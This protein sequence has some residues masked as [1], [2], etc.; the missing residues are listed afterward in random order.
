MHV[1]KIYGIKIFSRYI[2]CFSLCICIHFLQA[3]VTTGAS[4]S[5]GLR[6]LNPSYAGK[7]IQVRRTCDNAVKD[8]GFSACGGLDLTT[9]N[10]FVTA[11]NPVSA[12]S[13]VPAAAYS[14]RKYS[15]SY[16]GNAINVRRSCDNVTKDIGFTATGDLD[17]V[18]LKL[19]VLASNPL[20]ALSVSS[21]AAFSLRKLSCA[22]A[23]SAIN[24]RRSSDNTTSDIGFTA[25]G[26]LDT[27]ALKAF[28]GANNGFVT[29][30]YDQSGNGNHASQATTTNQPELVVAGV[31]NRQNTQ[32]AVIF[33]AALTSYL[34]I[35]Y[36][37]GSLN[38]SSASTANTVLARTGAPTGD[39]AVFDQQYAPSNISVALSWNNGTGAA[40]PLSMGYYSTTWQ[41]AALPV[42][43]ILNTGNILT[44]TI[45]SGAGNTTAINMYQNGGLVATATSQLTVGAIAAQ[46]FNIGK[47]WDNANY[48]PMNLQE[49]IVFSSALSATDRQYLEWG[50][51]QYYNTSG[52]S[53]TA[54]PAATPSAFVTKWY[55]Q[56][57]NTRDASQATAANQPRI[58]N[59]GVID[60][61]NGL[62]AIRYIGASNTYLSVPQASLFPL[63]DSYN[64]GSADVATA[65]SNW[66]GAYRTGGNTGANNRSLANGESPGLSGFSIWADWGGYAV[67]TVNVNQTGTR[68]LVSASLSQVTSTEPAPV[69]AATYAST[70]IT[71]GGDASST[72]AALTGYLCDVIFFSTALSATDRAYIE[73]SQ[74]QYYGISGIAVASMPASPPSG[75][76]TKWYDQSGNGK[77]L[78]QATTTNQPKIVNAGVVTLQNGLPAMPLDGVNYYMGQSTLNIANPYTANAVATRTG[79]AGGS[80]SGY[81][82]LLNIS[83]TGDSY[84]FMGTLTAAGVVNYATFTGNGA[85]T[86]NDIAANT[87]L[88]S[89]ALNTQSVLTMGVSTGAT[90]LIPYFN[91][92][93]LT[94]TVGTA[95]T[96][97]G[98]LIG[99]PYSG[100]T[101]NQLWTGNISEF[102]LFPSAI[103]TT[104]RTLL[105]TN[106][107]AYYGATISN[108]VYTPPVAGTYNLFVNGV[109]RTSATDSVTATR[110]SAGMGFIVGQT[111]ADFLKDNG[112]YIT[113]GVSC[114]AGAVSILNLPAAATER[115][116]SDWYINK[117][118]VGNDGGNLQIYFSFSDYGVIGA[119][120]TA[121]N[122]MLLGRSSAV[123]SFTVVPTTTVTIVGSRIV[124]TL[125]STNLG[126]NG[127]YTVGTADYVASP[128]PIELL[129]FTAVPDGN[130]VDLKWETVTET[131]NAYFTIEKSKDGISFTKLIDV[132]GAG[133]STSTKEYAETDYQPYTGTS[134]YRLKQTDIN[135]NAKYFPMVA[136][137][138]ANQKNITVYPNPI[139]NTSVF[140]I[141]VNGYKNQ[142]VIVVLRDIQ[143][144]EFLSKV[145]LSVDNDQVF[146]VDETK[147]LTPGTY[148]V[149]AT[150]NDKIYNYKLI[151][152]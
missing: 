142:E 49:L 134:Y 63:S 108:S 30:W 118:D 85:A 94:P 7:A 14:L 103:S 82:R 26:D 6:K 80:S 48:A 97:T 90:G 4:V 129:E 137:N 20:S 58:L 77:D 61:Q 98:F 45:L 8:I 16:A 66:W 136:V 123:A 109:G 110:S 143:G 104:Q 95:A 71:F 35:P 133:N 130:K 147:T 117:T 119:P 15:C 100:S 10:T 128:L 83:A 99:A 22:Y 47:R 114:P 116:A 52:P 42:D 132:P 55:D 151:V 57:G 13:T 39:A 51:S 40:T 53:L 38:F 145:L 60:R 149:T 92:T 70:G 41:Y 122:Y 121:P 12:I 105:E 17:T 93:A 138:F 75:Y 9:L 131:N 62:P 24:V 91:G 43:L 87:P 64:V 74:A 68:N 25:T 44:G 152:K 34:T 120:V 69:A 18:A 76:V 65:A 84:G 89:V 36:A 125:P 144:R 148:I 67:N 86:W 29:K 5:Y 78:L 31:I 115:W 96:A 126:A 72:Y 59:A 111:G 56:S 19:F 46:P 141:E 88:T 23:G 150:S 28:V 106:Q 2:L 112:D 135:G 1:K 33:S 102:T 11:S 146:I 32:P 54:F 140:T 73:W 127:Y 124:F 101:L 3:Q 37:A 139:D 81:Q 50:Q 113:A 21:A 27:V 107:A 79:A